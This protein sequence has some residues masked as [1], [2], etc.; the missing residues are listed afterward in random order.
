MDTINLI[1]TLRYYI[2]NDATI[3]SYLGTNLTVNNSLKQ[4]I[5]QD[6]IFAQKDDRFS[7]PIITL[8]L[9]ES[10]PTIRGC[11][12]NTAFVTIIIHNPIKHLDPITKNIRLKDR[13]GLLFRDNNTAINN[14]ATSLG[15]NLKVRDSAWV[16][17]ETFDD[18]S[19]GTER[20]HKIICL[21]KFIVGD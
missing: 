7:Y 3:R 16:S 20:L 1:K 19:Q 4:I 11:D 18:K 13:L 10:E 14:Q 15:I 2:A 6:G 5:Y 17:A 21:T 12:T 8:K 9:D